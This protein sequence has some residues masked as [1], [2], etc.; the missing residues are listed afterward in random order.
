MKK[1]LF[2]IPILF[3][4]LLVGCGVKEVDISKYLKVEDVGIDRLG[5]VHISL[6]NSFFLDSEIFGKNP[7]PDNVKDSYNIEV[8][9][10][11]ND[12]LKNGDEVKLSLKYNEKLYKDNLK[13]KLSL[14]ETK[15]TVSGLE[16]KYLS[17]SDL[18][19]DEYLKLKSDAT[20]KAKGYID[21]KFSVYKSY[22]NFRIENFNFV[23]AYIKNPFDFNS[24]LNDFNYPEIV[25]IYKF[26]T[27]YDDIKKLDVLNSNHEYE[28]KT[29][30]YYLPITIGDFNFDSKGNL[31]KYKFYYPSTSDEYIEDVTVD[32][33][34]SKHFSEDH[35]E[36]ISIKE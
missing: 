10:S 23:G 5:R 26:E 22:K 19:N 15:H 14:S 20:K 9:S 32:T 34:L 12:N 6:D 11:P 17:S 18:S 3:S 36:K 29:S 31:N 13:V 33:F 27:K 7:I 16:K 30:F 8:I 2:A 28:T 24:N 21:D 25:Y 1:F 35:F 4:T